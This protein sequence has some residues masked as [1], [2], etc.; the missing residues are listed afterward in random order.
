MTLYDKVKIKADEKGKSISA[1]ETE[2][3]IAN[4]TIAGWK[5]SRPYADTLQKVAKVLETPIE[6]FLEKQ[7]V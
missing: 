2:A 4:A 7:E 3:G 1:I 6:Y 5:S